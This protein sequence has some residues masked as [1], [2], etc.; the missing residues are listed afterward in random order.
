MGYR[1]VVCP[2]RSCVRSTASVLA[3]MVALGCA[4]SVPV[5]GGDRAVITDSAKDVSQS[6]SHPLLSPVSP[7]STPFGLDF[8]ESG[9]GRS[10]DAS[11]HFSPAPPITAPLLDPARQKALDDYNKRRR[12]WMF[13]DESTDR[14]SAKDR[15]EGN[16][17]ESLDQLGGPRNAFEKRLRDDLG[18]ADPNWTGRDREHAGGRDEGDGRNSAIR[19]TEHTNI[20]W[21]G[22]SE[23][24]DPW[25]GDRPSLSTILPDNPSVSF[26]NRSALE[27]ARRLRAQAFR[28]MLEGV[29]PG[30]APTA[31][32]S[33]FGAGVNLDREHRIDALLGNSTEIGASVGGAVLGSPLAPGA[34]EAAAL[35]RSSILKT[36]PEWDDGKA[37]RPIGALA[38]PVAAPRAAPHPG[39][40]PLPNR[41]GF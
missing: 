33:I 25:S 21:N 29:H 9:F 27:D 22:F 32:T 1:P 6:S 20:G 34:D 30:A 19:A 24:T 12:N 13:D 16:K 38:T 23:S 8:L 28:D 15:T 31:A 2:D 26:G 37:F 35:R 40:L 36:T 3:A 41:N 5:L 4:S 17:G 18:A 39:I 14:L 11:S 10:T 7:P